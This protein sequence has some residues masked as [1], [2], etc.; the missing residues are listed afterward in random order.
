VYAVGLGLDN[1]R[2]GKRYRF[3][4]VI[5]LSVSVFADDPTWRLYCISQFVTSYAAF[6]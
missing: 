6:D 5:Y 4:T 2:A 3:E 1:E